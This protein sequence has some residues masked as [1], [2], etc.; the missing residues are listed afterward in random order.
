MKRVPLKWVGLSLVS[1]IVAQSASAATFCV[2][3]PAELQTALSTARANNA[4]DVI[5]IKSGTYATSSGL[6]AFIYS[7]AESFDLTLQGGWQTVVMFDCGRRVDDPRATVLSGSD[8]RRGLNMLPSSGSTGAIVIENLTIRDGLITD[9]SSGAGLKISGTNYTGNVRLERVYFHNNVS[10]TFAGG[11]S[12]TTGGTIELRNN[13]FRGNRCD[14]NHCG[15][16]IFNTVPAG[17]SIRTFVGNNTFVL[18]SCGAG[19][20]PSCA[21]GGL[22]ITGTARTSVHN[23]LF[24]SND[25]NDLAFT[26]G[27]ANVDV[28][29]NNI[30]AIVGTP[31]NSSGNV[32][33]ANPGFVNSLLGDYRLRFSS[34]L[35]DAGTGG[36]VLGS[37]DFDGVPRVNG[38]GVDIGAFENDEI[39]F[40]DSFEFLQ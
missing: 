35:R 37:L 5:R 40:K 25:V 11:A 14:S 9:T 6:S 26:S 16:L 2:N 10:G 39:V 20:L 7:D 24:F 28:L 1:L 4:D 29:F 3:T 38:N 12:V 23:N 19:A 36:F 31:A 15:A 32:D 27:G 8:A 18:N 33:L 34:L 21:T 22:G 30:G 17:N 13:W